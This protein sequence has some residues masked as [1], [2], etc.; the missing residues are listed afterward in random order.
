MSKLVKINDRKPIE[1][2]IGRKTR[3]P[4]TGI[5]LADNVIE[6]ILRS[7]DA[8]KDIYAIGPNNKLVKLTLDNYMK[9]EEELFSIKK[10]TVVNTVDEEAKAKAEALKKSLEA[11]NTVVTEPQT[12]VVEETKSEGSDDKKEDTETVVEPKVEAEV[13]KETV[14][15]S[16]KTP[17]VEST[18]VKEDAPKAPEVKNY[19]KNYNNYNKNYKNKK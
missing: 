2:Y 13:I 4:I 18:A 8:P 9:S 14:A 19:N 3:G 1:I 11:R 6:R 10:E 15:E 12:P 5:R 16:V 7:I 17:V